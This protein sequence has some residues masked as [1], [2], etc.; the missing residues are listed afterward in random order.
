ME[1]VSCAILRSAVTRAPVVSKSAACACV[2]DHVVQDRRLRDSRF[3][4]LH[5][6]ASSLFLILLTWASTY[7]SRSAQ[8]ASFQ[9]LDSRPCS[10][11]RQTLEYGAPHEHFVAR[12]GHGIALS[13]LV[14][15]HTG[16]TKCSTASTFMTSLLNPPPASRPTR[17]PPRATLHDSAPATR[18]PP[19]RARELGLEPRASSLGPPGLPTR[20]VPRGVLPCGRWEVERPGSMTATFA[21]KRASAKHRSP[22]PA[23]REQRH[24]LILLTTCHCEH[25]DRR[26]RGTGGGVKV[27]HSR[28]RAQVARDWLRADSGSGMLHG[29]L[30]CFSNALTLARTIS[31]NALAFASFSVAVSPLG[32]STN[33]APVLPTISVTRS[34]GCPTATSHEIRNGVIGSTYS[35]P[36]R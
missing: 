16:M 11:H 22:P 7:R 31:A 29:S 27:Q 17:H 21:G 36:C 34:V 8:I 14:K 20:D 10:S 1:R 13:R 18:H 9:P 12:A 3:V 28:R 26:V 32:P 5:L 6:R 25:R 23:N 30:L 15:P 19:H 2:D 35:N 24:F 33:T 4:L